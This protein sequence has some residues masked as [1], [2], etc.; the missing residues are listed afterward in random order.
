[1][2]RRAEGR[3]LA[4]STGKIT[5]YAALA[6]NAAIAITKFVAAEIGGS[7]ALFSEGLHSVVDTGDSL[8]L[9][10]GL[11]LSKRPAT[12]RHPYGHGAEVYFWSTVVAMS[13]FG[14][15][16]G[17]SIYEGILHLQHPQ[18]P[19]DVWLGLGVLLAAFAFEGV[20]WLFAVRGFGKVRG[21]RSVWEAIKRSKDPTTFMILLEDSAALL[22]VVAAAAGLALAHWL[23]APVFDALGS[24]AIGVLLVVVGVVLG[25]ET[26]SLLLGESASGEIVDSIRALAT[27]QPGVRDVRAAR[28][29]H[30]GPDVVH[31]DLDLVV[32]PAASAVDVSRQIE[33]AIRDRHPQ[34]RRVSVRFPA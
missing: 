28:T 3:A 16:G 1:M 32:E 30:I 26:W 33:A 9:L 24:I 2:P 6:A 11:Y 27:A 14:M 22:G 8:L 13:I 34:I 25:R 18:A 15:G 21:R 12:P 10:L 7:S 29:M 17:V 31:V 23:D 19:V 5:V 4:V 20:S